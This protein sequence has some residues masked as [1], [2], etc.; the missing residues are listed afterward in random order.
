M[1]P[2]SL[3]CLFAMQCRRSL[4]K[5][6]SCFS[7]GKNSVHLLARAVWHSLLLLCNRVPTPVPPFFLDFVPF[8]SDVFLTGNKTR[9][10]ALWKDG[11]KRK[12]TRERER[13][14]ERE[15]SRVFLSW[16]LKWRAKVR[17]RKK[18]PDKDD[19][20]IRSE[21]RSLGEFLVKETSK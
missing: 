4:N 15:N 20:S 3:P 16:R 14:R 7:Q 17:L 2:K 8:Y 9:L 19:P 1:K 21:T 18:S 6:C 12:W 5:V 10:F 13:E 11:R